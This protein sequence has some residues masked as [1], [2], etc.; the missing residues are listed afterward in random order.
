MLWFINLRFGVFLYFCCCLF[1]SLVH[2]ASKINKTAVS[3]VKKIANLFSQRTYNL[4]Y[5]VGKTNR[6]RGGYGKDSKIL[7]WENKIGVLKT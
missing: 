6:R 3:E 1:S 5:T 2:S 7:M 4:N